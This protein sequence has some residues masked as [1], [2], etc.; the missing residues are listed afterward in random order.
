MSSSAIWISYKANKDQQAKLKSIIIVA[1][2]LNNSKLVKETILKL[3]DLNIKLNARLRNKSGNL[4]PINQHLP[5]NKR[6]TSYELEVFLPSV[7][8]PSKCE[9]L[10]L[11][12]VNLMIS[13]Y[14]L[15]KC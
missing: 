3:F 14:M 13:L 10:V 6:Q 9:D 4:I 8:A 1:N 12:E 11:K 2:N 7:R 15:Y 5:S